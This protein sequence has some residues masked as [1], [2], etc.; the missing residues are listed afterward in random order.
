MIGIKVLIVMFQ[1]KLEVPRRRLL[2]MSWRRKEWNRKTGESNG[3]LQPA[4]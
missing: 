1:L 4:R 2:R 3:K